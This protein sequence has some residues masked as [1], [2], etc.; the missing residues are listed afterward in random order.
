MSVKTKSLTVPILPFS[1]ITT[2]PIL[3]FYSFC[4]TALYGSSQ[5][6][7]LYCLYSSSQHPRQ[8][9]PYDSSSSILWLLL[10][11]FPCAILDLCSSTA[12]VRQ[13]RATKISPG[14]EIPVYREPSSP[15]IAPVIDPEQY[16]SHSVSTICPPFDNV[17]QLRQSPIQNS[18]DRLSSNTGPA[19]AIISRRL[20]VPKHQCHFPSDK[21]TPPSRCC[22]STTPSREKKRPISPEFWCPSPVPMRA[23]RRPHPRKIPKRSPTRMKNRTIGL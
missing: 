18:V 3:S 14:F 5:I 9:S 20:P 22:Q 8:P 15:A 10:L 21:Q 4:S 1:L 17:S 6:R 23:H 19:S 2:E 11:A 12:S 16:S 13:P 7:Y